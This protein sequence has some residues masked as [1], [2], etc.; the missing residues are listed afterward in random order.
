MN[1]KTYMALA[2]AAL[3]AAC[4]SQEPAAVADA[5][6]NET[7]AAN[8]DVAAGGGAAEPA[9]NVKEK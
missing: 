8:A 7:V 3:T 5:A 1:I 6:A 9:E 2:V 4:S